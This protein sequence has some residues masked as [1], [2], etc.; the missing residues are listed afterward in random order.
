MR[1][2]SVVQ[3]GYGYLHCRTQN[4]HATIRWM[5]ENSLVGNTDK[6]VHMASF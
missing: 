4:P 1:N 5:R 2:E 6:T 3:G